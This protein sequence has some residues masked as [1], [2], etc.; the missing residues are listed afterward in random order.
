M[1]PWL[2]DYTEQ[3]EPNII[4]QLFYSVLR[5]MFDQFKDSAKTKQQWQP[6]LPLISVKSL[7]DIELHNDI[8][9]INSR[10]VKCV[11]MDPLISY[12]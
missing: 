10:L 3:F 2:R 12:I 5:F 11:E 8:Q 1:I 6:E 9:C 7:V 4:T